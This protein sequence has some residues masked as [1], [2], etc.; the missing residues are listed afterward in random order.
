[1]T[2]LKIIR[3]GNQLP[4]PPEHYYSKASKIHAYWKFPT[5]AL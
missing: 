4:K 5:K 1:M 2:S 3:L